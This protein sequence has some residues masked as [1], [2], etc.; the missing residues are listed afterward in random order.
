MRRPH[1]VY[2]SPYDPQKCRVV[3]DYRHAIF[4]SQ[5]RKTLL[6][7]TVRGWHA[8]D[9]KHFF[10]PTLMAFQ[11]DGSFYVATG[12]AIRASS[13]RQDGK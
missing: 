3:D 1:S 13:S 9:D 7:T 12:T 11:N 6:Q 2:I 8:S 5:R 10:R 4:K